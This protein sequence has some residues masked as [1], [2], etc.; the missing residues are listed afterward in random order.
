MGLSPTRIL[1]PT[2]FEIKSTFAKFSSQCTFNIPAEWGSLEILQR[3]WSS[4]N[5]NDHL[6]ECHCETIGPFID[7]HWQT[8][9]QTDG[10]GKTISRSGS[11]GKLTR[12]DNLAV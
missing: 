4:K 10:I 8:D 5:Y 6:L 9:G 3:R 12:D 11:I 2:V 7:T 1:S